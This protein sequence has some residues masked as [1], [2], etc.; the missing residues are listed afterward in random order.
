VGNIFGG[1]LAFQFAEWLEEAGEQVSGAKPQQ[2]AFQLVEAGAHRGD[3][4]RDILGWLRQHRPQL[5]EAMDYCIV[6]PSE[7]AR[8]WQQTAL[9]EFEGKVRWLTNVMQLEPLNGIIFSNELL[10]A[11][12]VHR[13]S[14]ERRRR[15]WIEWGVENGDGEFRW[16]LMPESDQRGAEVLNRSWLSGL[17]PE[18]L[19]VLPDGFTAEISPEAEDWW[20][21]AARALRVGRLL[22]IDYGFTTEE[23][24]APERATGTLRAYRDQHLAVNV[25][26]SPGE[27]DLTTHLNFS[28]LQQRGEAAGLKTELF[29]TQSR[30]LTA[31]MSR[32]LSLSPT[33]S[34]WPARD[35]RQFQTLTNPE[36]LGHS[37]RVLIQTRGRNLNDE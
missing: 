18:L 4:A 24:L 37:F 33:G 8:K 2:T 27:Q 28:A 17:P 11:M 35:M 7:N 1:L 5:F 20:T 34:A 10:D 31:I 21:T 3:L 16:S 9:R 14:W 22:T 26:A 30:F 12:P 25:L 19:E 6:E 36:H 29:A 23:L 13:F 32:I 15:K